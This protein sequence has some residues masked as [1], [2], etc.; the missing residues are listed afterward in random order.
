MSEERFEQDEREDVESHG[1]NITRN[2]A[3]QDELEGD[4][5]EAH[6][7]NITR[8]TAKQDEVSDDDD[9]GDVEAHWR[10]SN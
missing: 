10:R 3:K 5:V 2:T 9:D 6:G 1:H 4:E 7:H 8:N